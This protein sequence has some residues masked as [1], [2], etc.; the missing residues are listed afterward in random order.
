LLA[1]PERG[2]VNDDMAGL[3]IHNSL[4][5]RKAFHHEEHEEHEVSIC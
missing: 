3:S 4:L 2:V 1:I 5:G